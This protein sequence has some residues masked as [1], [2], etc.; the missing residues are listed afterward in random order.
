MVENTYRLIWELTQVLVLAI[1][2]S[3]THHLIVFG[4]FNLDFS[5]YLVNKSIYLKAKPSNSD[6]I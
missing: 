5:F 4:C 1:R 3:Q 6:D 2:Q